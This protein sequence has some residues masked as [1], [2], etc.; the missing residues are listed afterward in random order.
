MFFDRYAGH[1]PRNTLQ[2]VFRSPRTLSSAVK[3]RDRLFRIEERILSPIVVLV[4]AVFFDAGAALAEADR[5]HAEIIA[6]RLGTL[7]HAF[8]S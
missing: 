6:F 7:A 2:P 5:F 3:G 1:V 8:E 4:V